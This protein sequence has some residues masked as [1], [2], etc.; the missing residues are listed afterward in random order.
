MIRPGQCLLTMKQYL[1]S[2]KP[3]RFH[4]KPLLLCLFSGL[5]SGCLGESEGS[6]G[7]SHSQGQLLP[8]GIS[9]LSYQTASTT[10]TTDANGR[11]DYYEGETLQF[12]VGDLL[13]T[14]GVP[15]D[16]MITP[17]EF[18]DELRSQLETS[19]V[20]SEG[21]LDHRLTEQALLEDPTLINM[22]RFLMALNWQDSIQEGEGIEIR[23]RVIDQ[24]NAALPTLE[25]GIDFSVGPVTFAAVGLNPSP[26][27]ILLGKIC[28]YD[29]I[30]ERCQEPPTQEQIDLA[31]ERPINEEDIDPDTVYREDLISKRDRIVNSR[32]DLTRFSVEKAE[33]F[34]TRELDEITRLFANRYYLDSETASHPA[35]DTAI[36][37]M[38]VRQI[39]STPT[40]DAMEAVSLRDSEVTIHAYDWQSA[41]VEYFVT[42]ESGG[43]SDLL[44]NFRPQ[45]SYR[46]IKKQLRVIIR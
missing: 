15:A 37:S 33:D 9:G 13:L 38:H 8:S 34:L 39:G 45:E 26:A 10:G 14:T 42:G 22:T 46:W 40:L 23:Q 24:L 25:Q 3:Y 29:D 12:S 4:T 20:N 31:P 41:T 44:I 2:K 36:H 17:L 43:E 16:E 32:R 19:P 7:N 21:L 30:D 35:T 28:F 11:F 6:D 27:N 18:F 1:L 5:M